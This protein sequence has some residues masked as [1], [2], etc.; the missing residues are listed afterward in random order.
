[1]K[2]IVTALAVLAVGTA[3]S[4]ERT[5]VQTLASVSAEFDSCL[6][7]TVRELGMSAKDGPEPRTWIIGPQFLHPSIVPDGKLEV[8]IRKA[9]KESSV[10]VQASWPGGE[11]P[12]EIQAEIE[13]RLKAMPF[14]M[15]QACGIP[16]PAVRC[17]VTPAGK[18]GRA[19]RSQ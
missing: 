13:E 5:T 12:K 10:V 2:R 18:K 6:D 9:E 3:W 19:C 17:T 15:V 8:R 11:K 14:K 16:S 7:H 4:A 1:M